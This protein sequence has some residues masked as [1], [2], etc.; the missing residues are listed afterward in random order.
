MGVRAAAS[1]GFGRLHMEAV[2]ASLADVCLK[3]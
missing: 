2:P 1:A 3:L